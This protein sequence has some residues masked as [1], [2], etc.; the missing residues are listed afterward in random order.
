VALDHNAC[1]RLWRQL[2]SGWP[3]GNGPETGSWEIDVR[4]TCA[5][6]HKVRF[7]CTNLTIDAASGRV[8]DKRILAIPERVSGVQN[9]SLG[10]VYGNVRIGMSWGVVLEDEGRIVEVN[11]VLVLKNSRGDGSGGRGRKCVNPAFHARVHRKT[12][13]GILVSQNAC[14]RLVHPIVAAGVIEV[15]VRVDELLDGV[16]TDTGESRRN[17][18]PRGDDFGIDEKLS[19]LASKNGDVSTGAKQDADIAPKHLHRDLGCGGFL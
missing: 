2:L 10:K 14:A 16:R 17:V 1:L 15:P 12:F 5:R 7:S 6:L 4:F 19:V 9:I 3:L 8:V 18:R 11:R 13:T